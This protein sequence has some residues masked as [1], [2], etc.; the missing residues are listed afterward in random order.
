[1]V[2]LKFIL[3]SSVP[4]SLLAISRSSQM[5]VVLYL[6]LWIV[7]GVRREVGLI[8]GL[9][10]CKSG[11]VPL[12]SHHHCTFLRLFLRKCLPKDM[13]GLVLIPNPPKLRSQHF[14]WL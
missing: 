4:S 9:H 3:T 2:V 7:A 1:M 6:H 13:P 14:K 10:S 11:A 12:E 8:S 5:Q